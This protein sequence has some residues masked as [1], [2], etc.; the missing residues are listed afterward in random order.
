MGKCFWILFVV[1]FLG[2]FPSMNADVISLNSGGTGN[3]ILNPNKYI[4]GF[5]WCVPQT[6]SDLGYECG[7]WSDG[8]GGTIDCGSCA[9]GYVC[10]SGKCVKQPSEEGEGEPLS[11]SSL[12]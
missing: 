6:C 12:Q 1:M 7:T 10:S 3:I 8:C 4:E 5:F 11:T 2:T 9:S